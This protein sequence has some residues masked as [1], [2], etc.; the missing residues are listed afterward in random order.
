MVS[1]NI[2]LPI[3]G[4]IIGLGAFGGLLTALLWRSR[5]EVNDILHLVV[6]TGVL[7]GAYLGFNLGLEVLIN[8]NE[9]I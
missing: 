6:M 8:T 1:F 4:F 9:S 7:L 5:K 2:F 3:I